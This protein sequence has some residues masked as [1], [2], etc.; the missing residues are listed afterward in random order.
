MV[1]KISCLLH[2]N[3]SKGVI[4]LPKGELPAPGF[5]SR[6]CLSIFQYFTSSKTHAPGHREG[7]ALPGEDRKTWIYADTTELLWDCVDSANQMCVR[8]LWWPS[9]CRR[10]GFAPSQTHMKHG[11]FL[12]EMAGKLLAASKASIRWVRSPVLQETH[13]PPQSRA[14]QGGEGWHSTAG[15]Q[16]NI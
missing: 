3:M 2:Q 16:L 12:Q 8:Y 6:P 14:L 9:F 1:L 13:T 4:T 5:V 15:Q 10:R 7:C 11:R